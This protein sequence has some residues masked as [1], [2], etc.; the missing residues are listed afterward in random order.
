[1]KI[2]IG[3]LQ[4]KLIWLAQRFFYS[5]FPPCCRFCGI[6]CDDNVIFCSACMSLIQPVVSYS[7]K[8]TNNYSVPCFALGAYQDPL[9]FLV[10]AKHKRVRNAAYDLGRLVWYKT[11]ISSVH[12]DYLVPVPLHWSRYA[13]RWYNQSEEMARVISTLSG[14]PVV[15]A[16]KKIKRTR[17]QTGLSRHDRQKNVHDTFQLVGDGSCYKDKTIVLVDDVMTTG[18][19]INSAVRELRKASPKNIIV[20]VACRVI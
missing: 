15:N 13:F 8:I 7:L 16:L 6:E 14:K 18:A 10:L 3:A 11:N 20:V 1:M 19:T 12:F 17:F 4:Q 5:V 9:R 2:S